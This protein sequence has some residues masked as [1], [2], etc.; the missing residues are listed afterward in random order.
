MMQLVVHL[1]MALVTTITGLQ[2]PVEDVRTLI[3]YL[4][5]HIKLSAANGCDDSHLSVQDNACEQEMS[6]QHRQ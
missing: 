5:Q 6:I 3:I 2:R 1:V 4:I